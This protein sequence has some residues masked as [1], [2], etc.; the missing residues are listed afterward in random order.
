MERLRLEKE[1]LLEDEM[2]M[3]ENLEE[4]HKEQE[5][6]L[7]EVSMIVINPGKLILYLLILVISPAS[8]LSSS[9]LP[10]RFFKDEALHLLIMLS[11][12]LSERG[13]LKRML[14]GP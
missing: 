5:K 3:R 8:C 14:R 4:R 13:L 1:Q 9:T 2:K 11:L 6:L 7:E 12:K 10:L